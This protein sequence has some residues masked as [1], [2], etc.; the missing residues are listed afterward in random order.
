MHAL[1]VA[2]A[3]PDLPVPTWVWGVLALVVAAYL[4]APL[5]ILATLRVNPL[6]DIMPLAEGELPDDVL[7]FLARQ[8]VELTALGFE[9]AGC[10]SLHGVMAGTAAVT[11]MAMHMN[12]ASGDSV[13]AFAIRQ[14]TAA[15]SVMKNHYVEFS[16]DFSDGSSV[17]TGNTSEL[18][19]FRFTEEKDVLYFPHVR[20]VSRL[21]AL[22]RARLAE[23]RGAQEKV[24]P[25]PDGLGQDL[26]DGI[27][28]D[29]ERQVGFG[30]MYRDSPSG[31]YRPTVK[32]AYRMTWQLMPP[33]GWIN[34][35]RQRRRGRAEERRLLG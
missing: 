31:L 6:P 34:R 21:H 17:E 20:D 28:R 8:T 10:F 3:L 2:L 18:G 11:Y 4:G 16:T 14:R 35:L 7:D 9:P 29:L 19:S 25:P 33:M 22:H 1:T 32:G 24:L 13:G 27:V 5:L 12:R 15:G 26:V 23:H 30:D